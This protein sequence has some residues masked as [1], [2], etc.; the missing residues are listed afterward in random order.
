MTR[1][2]RRNEERRADKPAPSVTTRTSARHLGLTKGTPFSRAKL[3]K[4]TAATDGKP[5]IFHTKSYTRNAATTKVKATMSNIDWFIK[6]LPHNM[7][8]AMLG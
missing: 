8:L 2:Q 6:G 4:I 5:A 7:K 1:Q 3:V